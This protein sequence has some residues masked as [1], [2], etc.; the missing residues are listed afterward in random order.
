[1]LLRFLA[2]VLLGDPDQERA[3]DCGEALGAAVANNQPQKWESRQSRGTFSG[4][5]R[6]AWCRHPRQ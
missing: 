1:V 2:L 4:Y 3:K 6:N 5:R